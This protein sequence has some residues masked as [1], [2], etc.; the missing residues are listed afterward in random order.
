[1]HLLLAAL[2][3]SAVGGGLLL[4]GAVTLLR[5]GGRAAALLLG[6]AMLLGAAKA[7]WVLDRSA[8]RIAGRIVARG[9]GKCL[10]GFLSPGSWALVAVMVIGGRLLRSGP[11]PPAVVGVLY[12]AVGTAL[13][14]SAR[15]VWRARAAQR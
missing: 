2:M 14:G 15:I 6:G 4:F 12:A 11:L 7:R 8:R 9:D 13:L 10:G 1:M 3:W 5:S